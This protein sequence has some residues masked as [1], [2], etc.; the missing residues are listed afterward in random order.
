AELLQT[1]GSPYGPNDTVGRAGL[2]AQDETQLAGSPAATVAVVDANGKTIATLAQFPA[3]P[4]AAVA[5]T[6]DPTVQR[7]AEAALGGVNG[8]AAIVAIRASTGEV[9]ATASVPSTNA[10]NIAL[11]GRYPPGSTFKI[12]TTADLLEHGATPSTTVS[13]PATLTLNGQTFRNFE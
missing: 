7:A 11:A 5:T 8:D 3:K 12:V 4:G 1:L 2:E 9:L 13:C 10:F 6:I